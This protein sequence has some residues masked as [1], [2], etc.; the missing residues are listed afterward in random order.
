MLEIRPGNR[1]A[2]HHAGVLVV[3]IP[4]GATIVDGR[5]VSADGT[6]ADDRARSA[7]RAEAAMGLPGSNKLLSWVPGRGLDRHRAVSDLSITPSS[8]ERR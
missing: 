7:F 8:Q 1:A 5:L 2:L 4:E 6:V 3:D